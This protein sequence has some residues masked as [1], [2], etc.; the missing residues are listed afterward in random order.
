MDI[1]FL[2]HYLRKLDRLTNTLLDNYRLII[3]IIIWLLF[4]FLIIKLLKLKASYRSILIFILFITFWTLPIY[5]VYDIRNSSLYY[6]HKSFYNSGKT[7][8]NTSWFGIESQKNPLDLWIYQ[9]IIYEVK[10]DIIIECGTAR[11]GS[12]LYFANLLDLLNNGRVIT[13]DIEDLGNLPKHSRIIYLK[14]S[15]TSR[16]I[17]DKVKNLIKE[18]D[19][20]LV[21]LDSDHHK[22]HVL[23]ELNL[24]NELVSKGSYIVVEDTN[25]NGHPVY[26]AHGEGP[27][28][29]VNEFLKN[30]NDFIVDQ[31]R[32]KY[33][34]TFN[35]NGYLKKIK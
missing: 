14:G 3:F 15:S 34:L 21:S 11:G 20:V 24:Y 4:I 26:I 18:N 10:P 2:T 25:I 9:E 17:F 5:L 28:E 16:E 22:Q 13:I 33:F 12:A 8:L 1:F 31:S 35:P 7:W 19:K 6:F 30:N 29:A 23:K 27:M 32:E